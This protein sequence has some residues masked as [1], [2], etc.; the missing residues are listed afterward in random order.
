VATLN[1][2]HIVRKW[3]KWLAIA[4]VVT[5]S[6]VDRAIADEPALVTQETIPKLE[7]ARQKDLSEAND[8]SVS[9]QRQAD[10]AAQAQLADDV[11]KRL[12]HGFPVPQW[13]IELASEVPPKSVRAE[14]E[15]LLARLKEIRE[16]QQRDERLNYGDNQVGLDRLRERE[17]QTQKVIEKLEIGEF[18]PWSDVVQA[19]RDPR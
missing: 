2:T 18:V 12:Q 16:E 19:L 15:Q 13:Q 9:P 4:C 8:S 11:I 14:K 5:F 1:P 3:P 10:C 6:F 17:A 7:A